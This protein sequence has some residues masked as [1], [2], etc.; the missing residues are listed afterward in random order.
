MFRIKY[1][2][3]SMATI[4]SLV[5]MLFGVTSWFSGRAEVS[6]IVTCFVLAGLHFSAGCLFLIGSARDLRAER[7]RVD[8]AIDRL[9]STHGGRVSVHDLASLAELSV[10]DARVYLDKQ[11]R[12]EVTFRVE[13][14]RAPDTYVFGRQY[15][16][17]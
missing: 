15:W 8:V 11:A 6:D 4:F 2:L 12:V 14:E 5:Y 7:R 10:E 13:N 1:L 17:N 3:G 16:N 9:I